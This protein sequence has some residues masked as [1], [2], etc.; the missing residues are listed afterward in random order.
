MAGNFKKGN[1]MQSTTETNL[2]SELQ[3]LDRQRYHLIRQ[4][5]YQV[6]D[7]LP[8]LAEELEFADLDNGGHGGPLI[9]QH[10]IVC[11]MLDLFKK[12]GLNQ[13]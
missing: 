4:F 12:L 3:K 9:E 5:Y 2:T 7:A 1:S 11:E 10:F 6:S 13:L 8:Q